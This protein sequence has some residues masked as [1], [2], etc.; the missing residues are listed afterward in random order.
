MNSPVQQD[1]NA[2]VAFRGRSYRLNGNQRSR[3]AQA[4]AETSAPMQQ[5]ADPNPGVSFRGKSYRLGGKD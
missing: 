1:S 2:G 4:E 5:A 3:Q